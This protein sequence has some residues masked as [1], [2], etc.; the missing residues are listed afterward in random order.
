VAS[1]FIDARSQVSKMTRRLSENAT[2]VH[3]LPETLIERGR[4]APGFGLS[5]ATSRERTERLLSGASGARELLHRLVLSDIELKH[6]LT[7]HRSHF[8]PQQPRVPAGSPEGGQWT[9][10]GGS[11]MRLAAADR[12][13]FGLHA[14][15]VIAAELAKRVIEAYRSENGLWDLFGHKRGAVTVTT[16]DGTDVFGSNSGSPT[17]TASDYAAVVRLRDKL[18]EKY[19][20]ELSA[21]NIGLMPHNA[22]FHAETTVLLRAARQNGGSLTGRTLTVFGDTR[23]CNNCEYVLPYVG[24]ELGNPTVTFVDPDGSTRMMR[25]GSWVKQEG[26]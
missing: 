11:G 12:P 13:R 15:S 5:S 19:P 8:N 18:A 9:S 14:F 22:L 25:D 17:Y 26:K 2:A 3:T 24:L 4:G 23:M 21:K 6:R 1:Q 20:K 7:Q 10:T 16:V